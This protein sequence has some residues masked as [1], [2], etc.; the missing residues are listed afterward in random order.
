VLTGVERVA[1][2]TGVAKTDL[3]P[4]GVVLVNGED[5]EG[6]AD[7]P[8][9]ARGERVTVVSIEGLTLHVRKTS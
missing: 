6:L 9:I 8:P 2:C 4:R 1:G 5:W 3:V 7:A